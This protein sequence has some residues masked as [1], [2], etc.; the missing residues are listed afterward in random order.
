MPLVYCTLAMLGLLD[1]QGVRV[2]GILVFIQEF[3]CVHRRVTPRLDTARQ[4]GHLG[5]ARQEHTHGCTGG[6]NVC[7]Q[8]C[9]V[10]ISIAC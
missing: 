2:A 8:K 7:T 3:L 10:L 9:V 4:S 6:P 1:L 5:A